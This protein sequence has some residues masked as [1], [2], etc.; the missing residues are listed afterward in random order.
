MRLREVITYPADIDAVFSMLCDP[1]FRH[2]VCEA[3]YAIDHSVSVR[4]E[5]D[6]VV[7]TIVRIMPADVP[8]FVRRVV[9]DRIGIQQV[10][11]WAVPG[12]VGRRT[13]DLSLEII[14]QPATM[15]GRIVL[16]AVDDATRGA[17][18]GNLRVSVPIFGG[19][20]AEEMAKGFRFALA[21]E[22]AVAKDYLAG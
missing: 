22:A 14:G 2:H 8:P 16:A 9:G 11:R 13:A 6:R 17:I 19:R 20:L 21:A 5:D 7:I 10:E 18:E 3:T 12:Q 15:S 4:S 1:A